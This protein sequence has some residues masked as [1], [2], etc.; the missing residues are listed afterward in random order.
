[1]WSKD[2]ENDFKYHAPKGEDDV[3]KYTT[4]RATAKTMAKLI[5]DMAPDCKER[6]ESIKNI[7]MAVMW[8]NAA[9]ARNCKKPVM[10]DE[11]MKAIAKALNEGLKRK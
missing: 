8:A 6:D 5:I 2:L 4:I 9:I 7:Q 11:D 3:N 1:M 10:T